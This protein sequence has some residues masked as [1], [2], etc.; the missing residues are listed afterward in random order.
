MKQ[1]F[2][3]VAFGAIVYIFLSTLHIMNRP[4]PVAILA[5]A[6]WAWAGTKE[7]EQ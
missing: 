2:A 3:G 4:L 6:M 1:L 5:G 7:T